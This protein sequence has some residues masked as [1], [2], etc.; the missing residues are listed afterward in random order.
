M[1][2]HPIKPKHEHLFLVC[3]PMGYV[4]HLYLDHFIIFDF[5]I[6]SLNCGKTIKTPSKK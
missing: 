3:L 6:L 4:S 2:E 5:F 1:L